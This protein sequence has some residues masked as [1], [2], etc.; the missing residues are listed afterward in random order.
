[1]IALTIPVIGQCYEEVYS[2]TLYTDYPLILRFDYVS[3]RFLAENLVQ[4]GAIG[5]KKK[6]KEEN[7]DKKLNLAACRS[8]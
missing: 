4:N 7:N 2:D 6:K 5:R 8:F 1:M 3:I